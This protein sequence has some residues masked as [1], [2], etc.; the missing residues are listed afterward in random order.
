MPP[1]LT[2]KFISELR[3]KGRGVTREQVLKQYR[4]LQL[5]GRGFR[6]G[7]NLKPR[8]PVDVFKDREVRTLRWAYANNISSS[9]TQY[10]TGIRSMVY[11]NDINSPLNG[12]ASG[13]YLPVGHSNYTSY[14]T[15]FKVRKCRVHIEVA[16]MTSVSTNCTLVIQLVDS[17][18]SSY[19]ITGKQIDAIANMKYIWTYQIDTSKGFKFNRNIDIAKIESLTYSQFNNEISAYRGTLTASAA[20]ISA[21]APA[22]RLSLALC[23][24]NNTAAASFTIPYEIEL[25]YECEFMG[26][27]PNT[28]SQTTA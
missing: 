1:R 18:G 5:L 22:R 7:K 20:S 24:I 23:L 15:Y 8:K 14:F 19:D 25:N 9:A 21:S 16:P 2:K 27:K 6:V 3:K 13:D 17:S 11:L 26:R 10:Q 28:I 12:Q 4:N